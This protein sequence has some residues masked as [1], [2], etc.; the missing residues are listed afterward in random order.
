M[1]EV[2]RL[3]LDL[4]E[5]LQITLL[6]AMVVVILFELWLLRRRRRAK[7][8]PRRYNFNSSDDF[9]E[10]HNAI[11]STEK[12]SAILKAQG[13]DTGEA[14]AALGEARRAHSRGDSGY[15]IA[16]ANAA[17]VTLMSAKKYSISAQTPLKPTQDLFTAPAP[18]AEAEQ[19][20]EPISQSPEEIPKGSM[21]KLPDNYLQSK[22]MLTTAEDSIRAADGCGKD[23]SSARRMLAQAQSA[24]GRGDYGKALSLALKA[25][26]L[27]EG[28]PSGPAAGESGPAVTDVGAPTAENVERWKDENPMA[29]SEPDAE[30]MVCPD[31]N[32]Q[33][34]QDD[35]FCRKCGAKLQFQLLCPGCGIELEKGDAF[36]RKC[37]AKLG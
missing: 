29:P 18:E 9:D 25:K 19:G 1:T 28:L 16:R 17:R 11:A 37:G 4:G 14:D 27:A 34:T 2:A 33:V 36:C 22:F 10:A 13:V 26:K 5:Q 8:S 7:Y 6:V 32:G 24:F 31:C 3:A 23:V 30:E 20:Y 12:I 15:A 21:P 35:A